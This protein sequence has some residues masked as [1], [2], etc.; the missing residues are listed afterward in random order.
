MVH[1]QPHL[2]I[3]L[4]AQR[5]EFLAEFRLGLSFGEFTECL[6]F[7]PAFD[8]PSNQFREWRVCLCVRVCLIFSA[9]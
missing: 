7:E 6:G 4:Q 3:P 5:L 1:D 8:F 2:F 9:D